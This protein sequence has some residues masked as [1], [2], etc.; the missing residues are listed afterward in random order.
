MKIEDGIRRSLHEAAG[1]VAPNDCWDEINRG[2]L[3]REGRDFERGPATGRRVLVIAVALALTTASIIVV[4]R[5]FYPSSSTSVSAAAY[6][7]MIAF[8]VIGPRSGPDGTLA[9]DI[10]VVA[11]DGSGLRNLTPDEAAY[12]SPAWSPAGTKIAYVRFQRDGGSFEE[13]IF[14]ANADN[15]QA[16]KVYESGL[17]HPISLSELAWSPDGTKI[18][19]VQTKWVEGSEA[20]AVMQLMV[21]NAEG[22]GATALG[23]R[24]ASN[25]GQITSFAWS[26][27]GDRIVFTRQV[28]QGVRSIPNLFLMNADGTGITQLTD[29]GVSMNPSWSPDGS[30]IAFEVALDHYHRRSIYVMDPTGG[31]RTQLTEGPWMDSDPVWSPDGRQIAFIRVE[32][33]SNAGT[34]VRASS[35]MIINADGTDQHAVATAEEANGSPTTPSWQP[36]AAESKASPPSPPTASLSSTQCRQ[37]HT[38]GDFDGDGVTDRAELVAIVSGDVFCED[39]GRV[40]SHLLSEQIDVRFGSGQTLEWPFTACKPCMTGGETFTPT[41]LDG[42][43][44]DEL[45]IDVGPGAA[46]DYVGFYRVDPH[47]IHPLVVADPADRPYMKPGPAIL[48]GGFDSG[49]WSPIEC[50]VDADGTRELVSVHAENIT[51]PITG[52]WKVHRTTMVLR[53]DNLIVVAVAEDQSSSFSRTSDVF[54]NGCS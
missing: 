14:V 10:D 15:T 2:P 48:G 47:G 30:Y 49:L 46:I 17:P 6:D 54:Q 23:G 19:F 5:A 36:L 44:R 53:G 24:S 16:T 45:A 3:H 9:Q 38:T 18:G 11:P 8:G 7:G 32:G 25:G 22:T 40:V 34:A 27:D 43:G 33:E 37:V 52:P 29:D 31:D 41:D 35:L 50:R 26:P 12:F 28:A 39:T 21:M 13:G 1:R 51:G 20:D 42:D 4:G